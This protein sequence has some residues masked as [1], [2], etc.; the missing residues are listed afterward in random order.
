VF[1]RA[2]GAQYRAESV[3]CKG[4]SARP[5][6][7]PKSPDL[8]PAETPKKRLFVTGITQWATG[9]RYLS[10]IDEAPTISSMTPNSKGAPQKGAPLFFG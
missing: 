5:A 10:D 9:R 1:A 6:G 4:F 2:I 7:L 8:P 3:I